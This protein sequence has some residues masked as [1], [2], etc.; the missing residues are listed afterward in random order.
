MQYVI[1]PDELHC[2]PEQSCR[3]IH[4]SDKILFALT[5]AGIDNWYSTSIVL[6]QWFILGDV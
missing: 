3:S 2:K 5:L 6:A 1:F 4:E